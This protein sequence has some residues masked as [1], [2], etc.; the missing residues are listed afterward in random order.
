[1][2]NIGNDWDELL[3]GEFE[4]PY[5]LELREFLKNE[6]ST[7]IIYPNMYDIFNA[8]KYTSYKDTKVLILGQDPYHGENQAHGL[9]F[10]VKPGVKTPPSLLNMYK[11]LNS[12]YGCFIPNN[13]FLVPWTEQGVLLLNTALTVRAHEANS[14]KGKGWEVFTDNIIKLLNERHDPVIFVLWGN[15][16]RSKKKLI[17][18]QK[19][20]IIESAHP[21]PL[22]A[23]RGFFGSKPFSKI[24]EILI[25]LGKTPID[26]QIPNI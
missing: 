14:H 1:M 21:S 11:E 19:H 8:L 7:K 15:N 13:G 3:K 5:Y 4:K 2:I 6:Y 22:S 26:W 17:D 18:T 24:N 10:S 16:A 20:Y 23:S 12:E 25:S 9:A